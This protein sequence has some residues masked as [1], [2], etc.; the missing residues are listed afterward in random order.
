MNLQRAI[1]MMVGTVGAALLTNDPAWTALGTAMG[2]LAGS[3]PVNGKNLRFGRQMFDTALA[4]EIF[5]FGIPLAASLVMS[6]VVT[7]GTRAM[8]EWLGSSESLGF[9]TAGF[10]LVQN[11]LVVLA[12]GI[13][14]AGYSL[15]VRAVEAGD[16]AVARQ[17]L[18]DNA[19]LL[20]MVM[21]PA[22]L[23]MALTAHGIA[24]ALV[25]PRYV[26]AVSALTPW[27]AAGSFFGTFRAHFL[28]HAFQLGRRPYL[29]IRVIGGAA[30][31]SISLSLWLIPRTGSQGAAV[32]VAIA[33]AASCVHAYFEGWSAYPMPVP[34][35]ASCKIAAGCIAMTA[36][37][38]AFSGD[39]V[40]R[41]AMQVI[42]GGIVYVI[43]IVIF[44]V[45][46]I[47]DFLMRSLM[48]RNRQKLVDPD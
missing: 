47:R 36:A 45:L 12:S 35:K 31:I 6:S 37:V 46:G 21:A 11:T 17:Q 38:Y 18:L 25:G 3:V 16:P 41:F 48:L 10:V 24:S 22:S 4:G 27:L 5:A 20:L 19:T 42:A 8:I 28:D 44:N 32:A 29:Q 40:T 26:V 2:I 30:V 43:M 9:Y 33:M 14:A 13:A 39:T 7:S 15:A 23:G 34:V 1:C